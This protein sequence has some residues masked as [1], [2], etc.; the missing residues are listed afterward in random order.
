MAWPSSAWWQAA[1]RRVEAEV[2]ARVQAERDE[3][4]QSQQAR[5]RQDQ[6]TAIVTRLAAHEAVVEQIARE[7][8]YWPTG[9]RSDL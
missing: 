6:K 4:R 8:V 7:G 1:F 5:D 9:D 2:R 3:A